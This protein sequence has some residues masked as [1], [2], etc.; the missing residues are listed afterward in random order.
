MTKV[1]PTLDRNE[2]TRPAVNRDTA[3]VFIQNGVDSLYALMKLKE[4]QPN[5]AGKKTYA[6]R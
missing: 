4:A 6:A 5:A 2:L 3:I 1:L